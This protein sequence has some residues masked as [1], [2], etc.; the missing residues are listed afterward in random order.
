MSRA[1]G[2]T[3]HPSPLYFS[4]CGIEQQ[5]PHLF[6]I[7]RFETLSDNLCTSETERIWPASCFGFSRSLQ[8]ETRQDEALLK[9][10]K[11]FL[12]SIKK[13]LGKLDLGSSDYSFQASDLKNFWLHGRFVEQEQEHL[14]FNARDS[15]G[16]TDLFSQGTTCNNEEDCDY[17]LSAFES[18]ISVPGFHA[19]EDFSIQADSVKR[20]RKKKMNKHKHRKLRRLARKSRK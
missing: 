11:E 7:A 19:P 2:R 8:K 15:V 18:A 6:P 10:A 16:A 1:K 17:L 20:K 5:K 4:F 12:Q 3:R 14:A 9:D 13:D